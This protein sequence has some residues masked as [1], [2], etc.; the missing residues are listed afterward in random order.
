MEVKPNP[1]KRV[2]SILADPQAY[3]AE[4]RR[5]AG[6]ESR[7]EVAEELELKERLRRQNSFGSRVLKAIRRRFSN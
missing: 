1:K 5:E 4:A 6:E 2:E 3:Y 7:A